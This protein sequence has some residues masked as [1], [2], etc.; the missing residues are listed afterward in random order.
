[1]ISLYFY[2]DTLNS[3]TMPRNKIYN[4]VLIMEYFREKYEHFPK[5][6]LAK[7][8]SPDFVLKLSPKQ[9]IGIELTQ[10]FRNS[11]D[12]SQR[13]SWMVSQIENLLFKKEEKLSLYHKKKFKAYWL[14][15][16]CESIDLT[17][18]TNIQKELHRIAFKTGFDKVFLFTLFEGK[19]FHLEK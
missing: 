11:S 5:G 16:T 6:K 10:L 12:E 2:S 1:M 9:S 8:E 19:I 18:G 13:F 14:V 15:I 17:D 7:I 3:I 4:E